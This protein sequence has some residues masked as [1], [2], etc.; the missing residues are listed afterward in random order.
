MS[1]RPSKPAPDWEAFVEWAK[2]NDIEMP[3]DHRSDSLWTCWS[4]SWTEC[5]RQIAE[6][7]QKGD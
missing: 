5:G 7:I 1:N 6:A 3:N 2:E 4:A